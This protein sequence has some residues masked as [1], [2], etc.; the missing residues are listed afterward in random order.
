MAWLLEAVATLLVLRVG[1]AAA[2]CP[3]QREL[4][5]LQSACICAYNLGQQ[6][7]VQCD[8][9]DFP[10]LLKALDK[11]AR[12]VPL[13]FLYV[14]NSSVKLLQENAFLN[15]H[16]LS[17][18]LSGCRIRSIAPGAFNGLEHTLKNLNLQDNELEDI[19][20]ESLKAL[21][22]LTLLDLSRNKLT[23]VPD[24]A[25]AWLTNLGTLKLA[26]NNV[27]LSRHAFRGLETSLKNLNLKA[28]RQK[29][30]PEAIRGLSALAFLDLAHNILS[31]LPGTGSSGVF[32][33]LDSLTALN[34]ERNVIQAVGPTTFVGVKNTLSSLSLLNNLL[35]EFPSAAINTLSELRVLDIGFNL[36]T[37]LPSEAFSGNPSLT[38]LALDGNPIAT[39]PVNTLAHLNDTLRGLSLGGHFLQCD[40][41]LKWVIEWIKH[42][43]LQVTSRE[44]N[45]QFCAAPAHLRDKSFYNI[46]ADDLVC[47]GKTEPV[48]V[49]SVS[50]AAID[51]A[52]SPTLE[53]GAGVGYAE[54]AKASP[55]P[56]LAPTA[57]PSPAVKQYR[58]TTRTTTTTTTPAPTTTTTTTT[59]TTEAPTT[60]TTTPRPT[61]TKRGS[62]LVSKA[63]LPPWQQQHRPNLVLGHQ[64]AS[65]QQEVVV[66]NALRQDNSVII[67]WD[68]DTANILGFR[69]IYRLFGDKSFK[70]GPPLEASE[71]EFKIKNVPSQECIIVCVISLE[72]NNVTPETVPYN[73]CKEVRTVASATN[74]MDKIT[75]A[76]SAAI[77]GT[78]VIAAVIFAVTCKRRSRKMATIP[79]HGGKLGIP[80]GGIPVPCCPA[81][82]PGPMSSL[83]T[84]SAFA[85]HKDWDQTSVYSNKSINRPR[86]H[87]VDRQG[88]LTRGCATDELHSHMSQFG[89][90]KPSKTRS[91]ADGQSQHSFSNHSARYLTGGNSF[92]SG[93]VNTRPELR[94]SRQSLAV[95]DRMSRAS[96]PAASHHHQARRQRP[97]SR[98]KEMGTRPGS[99]YSM[100]GS[101]HTLNNYCGDTSDNWTDHDMDIYMTRNPT[102]RGGLIPL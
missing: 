48:G 56:P 2:Q 21:K 15:I 83:A 66:K 70:Q 86:M 61:T 37:T 73:Q 19:P 33:G 58:T 64:P 97:R 60:S 102:A 75:I 80:V 99:R 87:Y 54:V 79:S 82:S 45:P 25:F 78:I 20:V 72:D 6:L 84:L 13:D 9:V 55:V 65:S 26:D 71:R 77:V 93:L 31:E 101:T 32:Q 81:S 27:T 18:Q 24:D 90:S 11:Y 50:T 52:I 95:S 43:D 68:S 85:S 30:I 62:V 57:R 40:C 49:A 51:D 17:L 74:N 44:R 14:N 12:S 88:T 69:V 67:Q 28:T 63:T 16:V 94:Q 38:L 39:I 23:Q 89:G 98:T 3:W 100:A 47:K 92:A 41:R 76:A 91:I 10:L 4:S 7:S 22:N 36:I 8:M 34:L 42:G 59:T 1:L 29:V 35:T 46:K 96:Y 53:L 5:E